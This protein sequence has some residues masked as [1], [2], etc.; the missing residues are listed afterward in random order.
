MEKNETYSFRDKINPGIRGQVSSYVREII[1]TSTNVNIGFKKTKI[2][3]TLLKKDKFS[4]WIL[5]TA[6]PESLRK[7]FIL[8]GFF[9]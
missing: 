6:I 8:Q 3:A 5:K 9:E 7:T 2:I 4:K 1:E